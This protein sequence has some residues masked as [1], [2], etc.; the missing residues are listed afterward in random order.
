ME[1][2]DDAKASRKRKLA[3]LKVRREQSN[4]ANAALKDQVVGGAAVE[5][6]N[7]GDDNKRR[8]YSPRRGYAVRH[9]SETISCLLSSVHRGVFGITEFFGFQ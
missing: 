3:A 1:A 6:A 8:A 5:E 9:V 7:E 2:A 4:L